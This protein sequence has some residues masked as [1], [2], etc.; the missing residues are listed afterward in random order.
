MSRALLI[1]KIAKMAGE[2]V[3]Q[4]VPSEGVIEKEGRANIVTAADLASEKMII[5]KIQ[6][7]F[8]DEEILSEETTSTVK[9][10]LKAE[11]LWVIDPIDGTNNFR[12]QRNFSAI[13]IGYIEEGEIQLAA[14]YDPFRKE[15]FFAEKGKGAF[16]NNVPIQV[17]NLDDLSKA[18]ICTGNSSFAEGTKDILKT[19]LRLKVTPWVM[20]Q[21]S[22]VLEMCEVATG[23]VDLFF[24]KYLKPWDNAA[25][26]L[27][28]QEAGA[29][30]T[31]LQGN[32]TNFMSPEVVIGNPGLV[33]QFV[34]NLT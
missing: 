33:D 3:K 20:I 18:N 11:R 32:Q 15:I 21:G 9:D 1:K 25:A 12:Y 28:A 29:K 30:V 2:A 8:P 19:I 23:R 24:H 10:P 4:A 7:H 13:S 22:A 27:I 17:G 14:A 6:Q 5:E 31:D 34:K 16:V 26:F